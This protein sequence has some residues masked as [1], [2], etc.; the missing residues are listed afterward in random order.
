VF[1]QP[2]EPARLD[3]TGCSCLRTVARLLRAKSIL[4]R[5]G[6]ESLCQTE[7]AVISGDG[8]IGA[9]S[10][11]SPQGSLF[12]HV[13]SESPLV[14]GSGSAAKGGPDAA[15]CSRSWHR[16]PGVGGS[17]AAP[18]W[19]RPQHPS[20]TS[21]RRGAGLGLCNPPCEGLGGQGIAAS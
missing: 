1:L 14:R 19:D 21:A 9:V 12:E 6:M 11:G 15:R 13:H 16:R 5:E 17:R 7:P 3:L 10:V 4:C 2:K 18:G 20:S 8:F